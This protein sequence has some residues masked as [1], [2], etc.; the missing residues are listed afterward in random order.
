MILSIQYLR[1]IAALLVVLSHIAWKNIQAGGDTM[2]WWHEAGTFGVDIF[3]I[4]SGFIMVYIT[5]N[6]H[7][8]PHGVRTFIKKRFIRI[9]PLYWF[10][11]LIALTIFLLMPERINSEGG[12]TQILKSFFLLPYRADESYL[13]SVGWT[14]HFEFIFYILFAFGLLFK[15]IT[16][17][18]LVASAI[19][20]SLFYYSFISMEG[21]SYIYYSFLNDIFFEFALGMLLFHI[22]NKLTRF[23]ISFSLLLI[24]IGIYMFYYLHTGGSFTGIRHVD[25]GISAFLICFGVIT[26]EYF[27]AKREIKLL[28]MLGNSSYSLYLLHPFVLVAVVMVNDKFQHII[29]Q[30][31]TFLILMMLF[32]SLISG[33]ISHLYIEKN[34]IK[35]TK[36]IFN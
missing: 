25:T 26:L 19:L 16:G 14:L 3:F 11:T 24:T 8:K 22:I 18:I 13:V 2:H 15:Q 35:L 36:K 12:E 17:N 20:F 27:L 5:Q 6:M 9:V 4:I 10:Y 28:T 23:H 31:Q 30:N 34:L 21:M 29:P 33:Y 32:I 7:Q 1:G